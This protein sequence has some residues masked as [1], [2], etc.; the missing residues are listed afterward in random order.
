MT[1]YFISSNIKY[2][3]EEGKY[4][5][6]G[7][8]LLDEDGKSID[9]VLFKHYIQKETANFVH[10]NYSN[11][12]VLVGAGASVLCTNNVIDNR[13][14]KTVAMLADL[15]NTEL[16][17][18]SKYYSLQELSDLC[19]YPI[20]VEVEEN[21][22]GTKL[23]PLFNLEDFL[24]D[25][26]S[27]EKYVS[28]S[29]YDKYILSKNKIFELIVSN[30]SYEYDN[31]C[32]KHSAFI[33][34]VAHLVRTPSKLTLVTTNYDTLIEDAADS[35]EY[36]VIDGFTFTHR[37]HFDSDMF[38]WNLV[39]DIENIKTREMEYKKNIIN[40]L[41][42][43][44]S[45]TWERSEKGIFRKEKGEVTEPI[46]I[47]PSSHKYMQSYQEPYFELFTK[48]QELLKRP[49][50]L[51]ITTGFSFADNHISQMI[52]QAILHNKSFATLI[53]DFNITQN[54]A[55]WKKI[56]DLVQHNY[57]VAF[58]KATMNT[59]LT[60]YLGEYYDD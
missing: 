23:N 59:D 52:I 14:G 5:K 53:T 21:D 54:N 41:K 36:T 15:I 2:A 49:N 57:K 31:T 46:M 38:E 25:M 60:D 32:L 13:F 6:N 4:L 47:F 24:S 16:K 37:P 22:V 11:I 20:S 26:L 43:H 9:A 19:K 50:T 40:L 12:I 28:D 39:K 27:F 35:I 7:A 1:E 51:L 33:N 48:F 58:L 3:Y 30:T 42:L 8:E 56:E 45:L 44:G 18:D 29:D 17:T 55:N 34:T 10:Q